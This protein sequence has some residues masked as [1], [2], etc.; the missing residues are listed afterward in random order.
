MPFNVSRAVNSVEKEVLK[1]ATGLEAIESVVLRASGV[2]VLPSAVSGQEGRLMLRAGTVLK[3][4][5]GDSQERYEEYTGT[6]DIAGILG[7]NVFFYDTSAASDQPADMLFHNCVFDKDKIVDFDDY[8]TELRAA[9]NTCR[10][11]EKVEA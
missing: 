11:E 3:K 8:E 9:L 6:G 7:D 5:S 4:I 10:F 1:F 2:E